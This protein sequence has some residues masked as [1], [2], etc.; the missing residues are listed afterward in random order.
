MN[1]SRH[2]PFRESVAP[3]QN[4][5]Q[6]NKRMQLT[7]LAQAMELRSWSA[8]FYAWDGGAMLV[9]QVPGTGSRVF[10]GVV[11]LTAPFATSV[12]ISFLREGLLNQAPPDTA[13]VPAFSVDVAT[14]AALLLLTWT[15]LRLYRR[16]RPSFLATPAGYGTGEAIIPI[17][18]WSFMAYCAT[19]AV[20][21]PVAYAL[22]PRN[23]DHWFFMVLALGLWLPA[24]F[25][26]PLGTLVAWWRGP[27][28]EVA[29]S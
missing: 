2:H 19:V 11:L 15:L 12:G 1:H 16:R 21:A 28:K 14:W 18:A 25:A 8:V 5:Q 20:L 24:W 23:G 17:L 4:E 9:D 29:L 22:T 6:A 3:W 27:A 7:K 13:H 10:E 26:V